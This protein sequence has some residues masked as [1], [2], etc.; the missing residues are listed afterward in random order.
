[1]IRPYWEGVGRCKE[2]INGTDWGGKLSWSFF[3]LEISWLHFSL[4]PLMNPVLQ[5]LPQQA[6]SGPQEDLSVSERMQERGDWK[7]QESSSTQSQKSQAQ[8]VGLEKGN[9]GQQIVS[10]CVLSLMWEWVNVPKR[11]LGMDSRMSDVSGVCRYCT[12]KLYT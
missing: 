5:L 11:N 3:L 7:A 12:I 4:F 10:F 8:S 2:I 1:M 6:N 9:Q